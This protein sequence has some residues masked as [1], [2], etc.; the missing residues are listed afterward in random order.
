METDV[1]FEVYK[2]FPERKQCHS[3]IEVKL[4][5][6]P[7]DLEWQLGYGEAEGFTETERYQKKNEGVALPLNNEG[8]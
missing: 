4:R 3:E 7:R 2:V 6:K 8:W 5:Q 1:G